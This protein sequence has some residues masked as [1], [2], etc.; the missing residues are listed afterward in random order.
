LKSVD[1]QK[2]KKMPPIK[3][4]VNE[5]FQKTYENISLDFTGGEPIVIFK[6]TYALHCG[7]Q[8]QFDEDHPN[9]HPYETRVQKEPSFKLRGMSVS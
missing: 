5:I 4:F 6:H 7:K 3:K 2:L 1:Q 9:K 8:F